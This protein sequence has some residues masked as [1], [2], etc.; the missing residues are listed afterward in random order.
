[1][2]PKRR[3]VGVILSAGGSA[4]F[5][6]ATLARSESFDFFV[7][8]DRACEAEMRCR[9]MSFSLHRI[10]EA[11]NRKFSVAARRFFESVQV[12]FVVLFYSRLV[13]AELFD[14]I[15]SYNVHP[16]LLPAFPG[17]G[18]VKKAAGSSI[19]G[20]TMHAVDASVDGALF[21]CN[22]LFPFRSD[23]SCSGVN[24]HLSCKNPF[25]VDLVG[26]RKYRRFC[27]V[28]PRKFELRMW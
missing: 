21:L 3:R 11:D 14:V 23:Q 12:E 24:G 10:E 13:T 28:S 8:T 26:S 15:P 9:E 20:A 17:F 7:V 2:T 5:Q 1:M 25:N 16:S 22:P 18:A 27:V 6:A 4:F 19:L